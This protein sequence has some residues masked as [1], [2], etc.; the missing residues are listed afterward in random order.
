MSLT[1][2]E[3]HTIQLW[4]P[5]GA[6]LTDNK[7]LQVQA[8]LFPHNP[9]IIGRQ[10][11]NRVPYL[12]PSYTSTPILPQTGGS[13]LNGCSSHVNNRVS[14]GHFMMRGSAQGITL[15]NGVPKKGGGIR[16]PINGT[17]LMAPESRELAPA[18]EYLIEVGEGILIRLPNGTVICIVAE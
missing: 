2:L 7:T 3:G 4:V 18:E 1:I 8:Q 17:Y 16:P 13:I 10:Q 14:R 15:T 6:P 11:G 9:V 12:D 5:E